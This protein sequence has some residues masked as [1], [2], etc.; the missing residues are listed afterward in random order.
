MPE[1]VNEAVHELVKRF[2]A[3]KLAAK[4]G[5]PVGTIYNKASLSEVGNNKPTLGEALVWTQISGD[6]RIAHAFCHALDGVFV[7]LK[8]GHYQSDAALL[9]LLLDHE[10][11]LGLFA[12]AMKEAL[13]DG[14]ISNPEFK[15]IEKRALA[16]VTAFLTMVERLRGMR[17][18]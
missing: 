13:D 4:T 9:D 2:G 8:D 10:Y 7:S 14:E 18:G 11:Q 12:K 3:D 17:H 5:T 6:Y 16:S 15:R 1:D